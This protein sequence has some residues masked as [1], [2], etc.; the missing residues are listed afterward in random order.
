[1]YFN[2]NFVPLWRVSQKKNTPLEYI[3]I[4]TISTF[5]KFFFVLIHFEL[6]AWQ[7][8][9]VKQVKISHFNRH[10]FE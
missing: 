2:N 1:M 6:I 7:D 3:L 5:V 4:S 9:L 10:G 8:P